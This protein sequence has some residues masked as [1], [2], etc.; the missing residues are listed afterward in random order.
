LTQSNNQQIAWSFSG[1]GKRLAYVELHSATGADIWTLPVE[2]GA[3]GLRAGKP[4]V[5][6][7]TP[8]N[9]RSPMFPP[10]GRWIA[11]Q[12]DESRSYQVYV[13]AFPDRHGKR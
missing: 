5:F 3:S 13:R 8:F 6:L 4:E 1:D 12:S 11:Y 7:Q 10:D 9:E 2:T